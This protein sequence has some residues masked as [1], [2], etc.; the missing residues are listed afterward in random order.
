MSYILP[1]GITLTV[2]GLA[3]IVWTIVAVAR[4]RRS[5]LDDEALRGRMQRI[6]PVNIAALMMSLMGLG[7]VVVATI[8]T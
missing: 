7:A 3:G 2:L 5:G 6:L 1:I 8:L 4:A